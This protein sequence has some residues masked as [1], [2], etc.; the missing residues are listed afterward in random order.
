[1]R[2][3]FHIL[4]FPFFMLLLGCSSTDKELLRA[5]QLME[6]SPDSALHIL[7][8]IKPDKFTRNPN[9]ALYALLMSQAL[10]KND[11]KIESDSLIR[12][13]NAY[14]TENDPE[15]A[16]KAYFYLARC[17]NNRGNSQEQALAL[18]KAQE[19][20]YKCQN[21]NLQGLICSDKVD[22]Y[23]SQEQFD[24]M[25]I[26]SKEAFASFQK[27]KS[28]GNTVLAL[29]ATG[30]GY[31][32]KAQYDSAV[33]YYHLAEK[34][35]APIH[36]PLLKSTIYK[37]ISSAAY[38]QN[39]YALA[40]HYLRITP[41]TNIEIY[42]LN[43]CYLIGRLFVKMGKLDS[44]K[45]YLYRVKN[46]SKVMIK[47]YYQIWQE[48]YEKQGRLDKAL[49]FAKRFTETKDSLQKFSLANSFAG[50]EKKYKYERLTVENKNLI[51]KNKQTGIVLLVC[52][53]SLSVFFLV[54]FYW[55]V[56]SNKR[57]I[58][59]QKQML[60]QGNALLATQ[61]ENNILMQQQMNVQNLLLKNVE[62]YR[63]RAIKRTASLDDESD[64][65]KNTQLNAFYE[66]LINHIDLMH[67][68]ISK[69][70][71]EKFPQLTQRDILICCLILANF[72]S[73]M[74][75]TILEIKIESI[76][77]QRTRLRKKLQIQ[78]HNNLLDFL[79]SF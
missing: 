41:L 56:L 22:M 18:L 30:S 44:A 16:A 31:S 61:K 42:D 76:Q 2:C 17:E 33:Y 59:V 40:L 6:T 24:S 14:Y 38:N 67:R 71:E 73:G 78:N 28:A 70:L 4:I 35:E 74:I 32:L 1:M 23:R 66:E 10:D 58:G 47:D 46:P 64:D 54:F 34:I 72:D 29:I 25:I 7:Q 45:V 19:Y 36:D 53:L 60:D 12:L 79:R 3:K 51:I 20:A 27:G 9:L 13:A 50:M 63:K 65:T 37:Y 75:S 57:K 49:Y 39:N 48:Y 77:K 55:R 15:H 62:Q 43:T 68:N 21:Y 11:I 52:L 8:K 5:E 69:R 26:Y